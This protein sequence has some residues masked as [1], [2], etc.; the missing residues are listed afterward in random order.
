MLLTVDIGNSN[1][2][3]GFFEEDKI[4]SVLRLKTYKTPDQHF[5]ALKINN[6]ILE[7]NLK[8]VDKVIISSVVPNITQSIELVTSKISNGPVRTIKA[9]D[10][11]KLDVKVSNP[12]E[13][14]IDL[15]ANAL[16]AFRVYQKPTIVVD[17]GTALTFT[18]IDKDGNILG[19]AIAPGLETAVNSLV[20]KTAQLPT[21][22]LE[23]PDSVIGKNTIHAMQAGVL[24]GYIGLI[25]KMLELIN[26]ELALEDR[27]KVIAT[28]GLAVKL[29]SLRKHFDKTDQ[30][31]TLFGIKLI[32]EQFQ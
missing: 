28:G 10:L 9:D 31:L 7:N 30:N 17:F 8:P 32:G 21:I 16:A 22:P 14:G 3:F 12:D 24:F 11:R 2:V 13:I 1:I 4:E 15:V 19:V 23:I 18:V 6:H 26:A 27:C 20:D 5:Y 29:P 25:E